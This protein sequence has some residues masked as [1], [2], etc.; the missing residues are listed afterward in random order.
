MG[1]TQ[2][3]SIERGPYLALEATDFLRGR[4]L[5]VLRGKQAELEQG[6][7]GR[8]FCPLRGMHLM[9]LQPGALG[10]LGSSWGRDRALGELLRAGGGGGWR[11]VSLPAT[12]DRLTSC[13]PV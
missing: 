3:D 5:P 7:H 12:E 11:A 10:S 8:D 13:Q 6:Y 4:E 9:S 2:H 1:T